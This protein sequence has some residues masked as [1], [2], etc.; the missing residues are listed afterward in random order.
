MSRSRPGSGRPEH[1]GGTDRPLPVPRRAS[2]EREN[3][4][5]ECKAA[6]L[7]V[8]DDLATEIESKQQ[9]CKGICAIHSWCIL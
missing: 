9:L 2:T 3:F 7:A 8:F 6:Y 1:Y 4:V 5:T